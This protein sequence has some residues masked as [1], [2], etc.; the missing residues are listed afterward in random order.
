[1]GLKTDLFDRRVRFNAAGFYYKY[2]NIQVQRYNAVSIETV[3]GAKARSYGV[4]ADLT[5]ILAPGLQF[6]GGVTYADATFRSF[7]NCVLAAPLGGVPLFGGNCDGYALPTAPKTTLNAIL[8]YTTAFAGGLIDL[9]ANV[10]YNSGYVTDIANV[11]RQDK[12][13]KVGL[14]AKWT[15]ATDHFSVQ[16]YGTNLTNERVIIYG[17]SQ[18]IGTQLVVYGQPR[19]YGITLGYKY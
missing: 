11:I 2:N 12:Y 17:D 4:D 14:F 18:G 7:P 1:M 13:A 15:D 5:A 9:N 3:N 6:T 19:T 8:D 16:I 10:Y